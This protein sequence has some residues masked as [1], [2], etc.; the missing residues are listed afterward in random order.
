MARR[1]HRAPSPSPVAS[2]TSEHPRLVRMQAAA[3]TAAPALKGCRAALPARAPRAQRAVVRAQ[4]GKLDV[5]VGLQA[6][7]G[8]GRVQKP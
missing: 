3:F 4:A 5:Q 1:L 7:K 8:A 2:R 6:G